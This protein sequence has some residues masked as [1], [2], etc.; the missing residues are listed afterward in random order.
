MCVCVKVTLEEFK[1]LINQKLRYP[2]ARTY[3]KVPG[4][5]KNC[6]DT[7]ATNLQIILLEQE[8]Y[9]IIFHGYKENK[10]AYI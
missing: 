6:S 9:A 8:T 7:T 5:P 10:A 3:K 4:P 1:N 2:V